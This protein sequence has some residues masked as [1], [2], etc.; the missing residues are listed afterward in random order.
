MS[1]NAIEALPSPSGAPIPLYYRL[2]EVLRARIIS[3]ELSVGQLFP[4]EQ[5]LSERYAVS[6]TT[7]REA[8]LGLVRE[9][10]LAR[11]QGKGTFVSTPKMERNL[12]AL[13]DFIEE[14]EAW[15]LRPETRTL[16]TEVVALEGREAELLALP[17]GTR[18]DRIVRLRL[19]NDEPFSLE[20]NVFPHDLGLRLTPESLDKVGYYPL[21]E[22]RY[23]IHL[24][25]AEQTIEARPATAEEAQLLQVQ[26]RATVVVLERVSTDPSG[27]KIELVRGVYRADRFR[28]RV[29]LTR[30]PKGHLQ[31]ENDRGGTAKPPAG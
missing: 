6:R 17:E 21:L 4:T 2:R 1:T 14:M 30:P 29:Q 11:K 22:E 16:S 24:A 12:A 10:L 18:A 19:G 15:G 23:G 7:V 31:A 20:T 13:T 8:I 27:R 26:R 3:G 28:Y 5:E 9:G 25:G